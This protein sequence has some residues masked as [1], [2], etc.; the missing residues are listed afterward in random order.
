MRLSNWSN[1]DPVRPP[2]PPPHLLLNWWSDAAGVKTSTCYGTQ[3]ACMRVVLV[4]PSCGVPL[5]FSAD[6]AAIAE[7]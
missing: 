3:D 4:L 2:A 7:A 6:W 1:R 5:P